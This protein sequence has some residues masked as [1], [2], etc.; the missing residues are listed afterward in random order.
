MVFL[1]PNWLR[2]VVVKDKSLPQTGT[3]KMTTKP[4][5]TSVN[6]YRRSSNPITGT[7]SVTAVARATRK[8]LE[9]FGLDETR[10]E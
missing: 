4:T 7:S 10:A 8:N 6:T 2:R 1:Y 5:R 9:A 3:L